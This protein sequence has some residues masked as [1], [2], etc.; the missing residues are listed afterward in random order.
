MKL[1]V[2]LWT[3]VVAEYHEHLRVQERGVWARVRAST[4]LLLPDS[5]PLLDPNLKLLQ[6]DDLNDSL[7]KAFHFFAVQGRELNPEVLPS[8]E[9]QSVLEVHLDDAAKNASLTT[10]LNTVKMIEGVVVA[11]TGVAINEASPVMLPGDT[12]I[13]KKLHEDWVCGHHLWRLF[14]V[15]PCK[16]FAGAL[17]V[18]TPADLLHKAHYRRLDITYDKHR[19][20][21]V[22]LS[23]EVSQL[24]LFGLI[25]GASVCPLTT[26]T[27]LEWQSDDFHGIKVLNQTNLGMAAMTFQDVH[28][29][30]SEV[31][32]PAL[33]D[34]SWPINIIREEIFS[35][36]MTLRREGIWQYS[37][38]NLSNQSQTFSVID[39]F[40]ASLFEPN[41][42]HAEFEA[43]SSSSSIWDLRMDSP[44]PKKLRIQFRARVAPKETLLV[45][46][47]FIKNIPQWPD[48]TFLV[49]GG[50]ESPGPI[51][52][53]SD[54]ILQHTSFAQWSLLP[55][56]DI[57]AFFNVVAVSSLGFLLVYNRL[58]KLGRSI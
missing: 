34:E 55:L 43:V 14:R 57:S 11:M 7:L 4:S 27:T 3:C 56:V 21:N 19:A 50:F 40:T 22:S 39:S 45:K 2:A 28:D 18:V 30:L 16:A 52:L 10:R 24:D 36:E 8:V 44:S 33:G 12:S 5:S 48:Y 35:P 49:Q 38:I 15:A 6:T 46:L 9:G 31:K 32:G 47:P 25:S 53:W 17:S 13:V 51:V 26:T 20:F 58:V 1:T 41:L 29:A 37:L 54:E 23:L 42:G